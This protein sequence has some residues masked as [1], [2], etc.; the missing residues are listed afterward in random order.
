MRQTVSELNKKEAPQIVNAFPDSEVKGSPFEKF[1]GSN[2][3]I[4][5]FQ[6]QNYILNKSTGTAESQLLLFFKEAYSQN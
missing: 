4:M 3:N 2:L 1:R 6:R 5:L